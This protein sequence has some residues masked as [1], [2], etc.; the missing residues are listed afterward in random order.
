MKKG[1]QQLLNRAQKFDDAYSDKIAGMYEGANPFVQA[2]AYT[3]GGAHPSLR[4]GQVEM[5]DNPQLQGVLNYAI[6]AANAVPKYVLPAVGV[7][8]AG[9]ALMDLATA[10]NSQ[11]GDGQESGQIL[12]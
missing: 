2:L 12:M 5:A 9:K 10:V 11:L 6:P 8:A 3:A 7:T 4:K 1:L